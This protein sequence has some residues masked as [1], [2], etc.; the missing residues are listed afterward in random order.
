M[1]STATIHAAVHTFYPG[2]PQDFQ[3]VLEQHLHIQSSVL[4]TRTR[5]DHS[6]QGRISAT[7]EMRSGKGYPT[8][9]AARC[10]PPVG[11]HTVRPATAV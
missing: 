2:Y 8:D 3:L 11:S 10:Q 9:Q 1:F 7:H 4:E 6:T 5:Q